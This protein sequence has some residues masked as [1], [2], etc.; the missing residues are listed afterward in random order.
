MIAAGE[1]FEFARKIGERRGER[2]VW[3]FYLHRVKSDVSF[4]DWRASLLNPEPKAEE[5]SQE[6]ILAET[7]RIAAMSRG[8][9]R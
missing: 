9:E 7:M 5:M 4:A 6:D 8:G 3:E 2:Q 1:L